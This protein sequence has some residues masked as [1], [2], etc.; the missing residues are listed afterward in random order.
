MTIQSRRLMISCRN[1]I[2]QLGRRP[3]VLDDIRI[4]QLMTQSNIALDDDRLSLLAVHEFLKHGCLL[5]TILSDHPTRIVT[6][7]ASKVR[8]HGLQTPMYICK[9]ARW[10]LTKHIER[11]VG[12]LRAV[13]FFLTVIGSRLLNLDYLLLLPLGLLGIQFIGRIGKAAA[14]SA[15]AKLQLGCLIVPFNTK[16]ACAEHSLIVG[17][18]VTLDDV[19]AAKLDQLLYR[20]SI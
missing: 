18:S 20:R 19:A 3:R 1:L 16:H 14:L 6:Q 4:P 11:L 9:L 12:I 17:V 7:S 13:K 5:L 2:L 10:R 15:E 8:R